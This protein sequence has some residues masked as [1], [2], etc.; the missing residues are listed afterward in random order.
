LQGVFGRGEAGN[1][2]RRMASGADAL[3]RGLTGAGMGVSE[4]GEYANRYLPVWTDDAPTLASKL[5]SLEADLNAVKNGALAGKTGNLAAFLPGSQM[6]V[7]P[8]APAAATTASPPPAP[9]VGD[10]VQDTTAIPEG[11]TVI[12]ESGAAYRMVNGKLQ[13]V[14]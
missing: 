10:V 14:Q 11:A 12:D 3:R 1:I 2:H 9:K 4:S 8:A 6:F 7:T 13:K 5:K